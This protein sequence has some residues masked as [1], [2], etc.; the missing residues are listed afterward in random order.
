MRFRG[1]VRRKVQKIHFYVTTHEH[2]DGDPYNTLY[3]KRRKC[4]KSYPLISFYISMAAV[5]ALHMMSF[6]VLLWAWW[7]ETDFWKILMMATSGV[8][9]PIAYGVSL[10][11]L[12]RLLTGSYAR[13]RQ[14][15]HILWALYVFI[16][17]PCVILVVLF[18][19]AGGF[20]LF[21]LGTEQLL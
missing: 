20:L 10:T 4:S 12:Y 9:A 14:K 7:G 19:I 1:R 13:L 15:T 18:F 17:E 3:I 6:V 16:A 8:L 2:K 11:H 21:K 5:S